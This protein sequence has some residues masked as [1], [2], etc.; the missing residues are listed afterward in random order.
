MKKE[1]LEKQYHMG[2]IKKC[3]G[4]VGLRESEK[5]IPTLDRTQPGEVRKF[6]EVLQRTETH[7][8]RERRRRRPYREY[9][10]YRKPNFKRNMGK[11]LQRHYGKGKSLER[12]RGW[13]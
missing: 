7:N 10:L 8:G 9:T 5:S 6:K 11:I 2:W 3:V 12:P 4:V 13:K 1:K